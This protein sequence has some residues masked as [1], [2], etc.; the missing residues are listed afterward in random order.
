M[1]TVPIV[2]GNA[3]TGE[4]VLLTIWGN[5]PVAGYILDNVMDRV[6]AMA[7]IKLSCV[8]DNWLWLQVAT[9]A[10]ALRCEQR[11]DNVT[12]CQGKF[13][14]RVKASSPADWPPGML[15]WL[16][17]DAAQPESHGPS[18]PRGKKGGRK[19]QNGRSRS[20]AVHWPKK[21]NNKGA[22]KWSGSDANKWSGSDWDNGA[23]G[24]GY[25]KNW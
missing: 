19:H 10:Q 7:N 11:M 16:E 18:K 13:L 22:N 3:G 24:S 5:A 15:P 12:M 4:K 25:N 14:A 17:Q 2:Q 23:S 21:C 6:R 1:P 20:P 9:E 8:A